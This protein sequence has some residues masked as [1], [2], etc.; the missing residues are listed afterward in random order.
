VAGIVAVRFGHPYFPAIWMGLVN[1][2]KSG[3]RE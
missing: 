1:L 2:A 3:R